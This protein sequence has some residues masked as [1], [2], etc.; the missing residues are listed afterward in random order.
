MTEPNSDEGDTNEE[1]VRCDPCL[2]SEKKTEASRFCIECEEHL[3]DHCTKQ[4][5]SRKATQTHKPISVDEK[6]KILSKQ[7]D[8]CEG[9]EASRYCQ[10]CDEYLCSSCLSIHGKRKATKSHKPVQVD[11]KNFSAH[12]TESKNCEV[13]ALNGKSDIA[14]NYCKKCEEFLCTKCTDLHK[15]SKATK[16]HSPV[17]IADLAIHAKQSEFHLCEPCSRS[18]TENEAVKFCNICKEFYCGSCSKAHELQKITSSH[19]LQDAKDIE[20]QTVYCDMCLKVNEKNIAKLLCQICCEKLC[21]KCVSVHKNMKATSKHLLIDIAAENSDKSEVYMCE[22]CKGRNI[23]T[24]AAHHCKDCSLYICNE[25]QVKHVSQKAFRTHKIVDAS[26]VIVAQCDPCNINNDIRRAERFCVQCSEK[27]CKECMYMHKM[28][29]VTKTHQLIDVN[30]ATQSNMTN[31]HTVEECDPCR[32]RGMSVDAIKFCGQC[33]EYLCQGC[34]QYHKRNK[35]FSSH[36]LKDINQIEYECYCGPCMSA[37]KTELNVVSFCSECEE[38]LCEECKKRHK[39]TKMSRNHTLVRK[40]EGQLKTTETDVL[41]CG[42]CRYLDKSKKANAFCKQCHEL[43]C[44]LCC[45]QHKALKQTRDHQ[46]SEELS[47]YMSTEEQT[48]ISDK[49]ILPEIPPEPVPVEKQDVPG[50]PNCTD[51][52]ADSVTLTWDMPKDYGEHDYFQIS[53]K[54]VDKTKWAFFPKECERANAVVNSL[55]PDTKYIFRVRVV[56]PDGEGKYSKDSDVI[57]TIVSPAAKLVDFSTVIQ[58]GKPSPTVYGIPISEIANTRNVIAKTRKFEVGKRR[59]NVTKEKTIMVVGATGTGKS[60][61]VDGMVNYL[62]GV[63]WVDQFR[64]SIIDLEAEEKARKGNQAESQTEWI[65]V[66]TIHPEPGGRLD[67]RLSII[68][69]PGFGDTRGLDRD[70][71]IVEQIRSLFTEGGTRGVTFIDAICFLI[72]APDARLTA[73][74]RYIFQ[75]IMALFGKDVEKN[76]CS[77]ITFA[78]GI[79]PPVLAALKASQLPF[80][81]YFTFNNSGLFTRN[82][83]LESSNLSPM[84]WDMG[85][86]SFDAFFCHIE[87]METKS[88][89]QTK[90]VLDERKTLETTVQNLQPQVD[91]GLAKL[92]QLSDEIRIISQ[93]KTDADANKNFEY[94]VTEI[95]QKKHNLPKGQHTTNCL[96]C[97]FTCHRR[98]AFANDSDK[99]RCSA[100]RN[101]Y[102][103]QCSDKCHWQMHANTPYIFEYVSVKKKKTYAE[104]LKK[105]QD[106]EGKRLSREQVVERMKNELGQLQQCI[107]ALM[108]TVRRSNERLS[109]IALSPNPLS[110][111]DHI[112]LMIKSE[113]LE[114]KPGYPQRIQMLE[115]MKQRALTTSRAQKLTQAI[116]QRGQNLKSASGDQNWLKKLTSLFQ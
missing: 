60:T 59:N 108:E 7:C 102:C 111:V 100:M 33:T 83:N 96:H 18:D 104:K 56:H 110:M 94:E 85:I 14:F 28:N 5:S 6:K 84:F 21:D 63:N 3:C 23:S 72:K 29:E 10:E 64:F 86:K 75:S 53:F 27:F 13:C 1:L 112:E 65:T 105:Y 50:K 2:L 9:E 37:D 15:K 19:C 44:I 42:P 39:G 91:A 62:L 32:S 36:E 116:G 26:M 55:K 93:H 48:L 92:N 31:T 52:M 61:L 77:L 88:L 30:E 114:K 25:C 54:E 81:K 89:K 57:K 11:Y 99:E 76:I 40:E 43:L 79:D 35:V 45:K 38:F 16:S 20:T 78:D 66:Y 82:T 4:H 51:A 74:Q 12:L 101:G 115:K 58:P 87:K 49:D 113:D 109:A 68:D 67:F 106:A 46:I 70:N 47:K 34:C 107:E 98:C 97:N 41:L 90:D 80:G 73:I 17:S 95:E 22:P 24:A 103:T 69:T 8:T 71:Q